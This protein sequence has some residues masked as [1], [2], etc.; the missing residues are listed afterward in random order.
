[1][2]HL[3]ETIINLKEIQKNNINKK[4]TTDENI[5]EMVELIRT[6]KVIKDE[7]IFEMRQDSY[8]DDSLKIYVPKYYEEMDKKLVKIKYPNEGRPQI[9]LTDRSGT[10]NIGINKIEQDLEAEDLLDFRDLM[11]NSFRQVYPSAKM[12]DVGDTVSAD[13]KIAYYS[14]I[15]S[16]IGGKLYYVIA[17]FIVDGLVMVV[18]MS[19]LK[20]DMEDWSLLFYG[21]LN[22]LEFPTNE[23]GEECQEN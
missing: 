2:Q 16:A 5:K 12:V 15:N 1:M 11:K 20:K 10:V 22:S 21:I 18:S 14:F 4:A 7:S 8:F 13:N 3:D 9:I 23:G 6:D 17:T 19:C